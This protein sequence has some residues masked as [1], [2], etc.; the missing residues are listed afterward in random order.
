MEKTARIIALVASF[1]VTVQIGMI[2]VTGSAVCPT[3]ACKIVE[4]LTTIGP[5]GLNLIGVFYFLTLFGV[6]HWAGG[7][8]DKRLS[9]VGLLLLAG[10]AA[11]MVLF[12]FQLIVVKAFCLY[13]LFIF[14]AI[15]FLN[16]LY[17]KK[18]I[19]AGMAVAG[20]ILIGFSL[21]NFKTVQS[22]TNFTLDEGVF[23]SR[24]CAA[25]TKE[26]YLIFSDECPHCLEV[27][28]A[29]EECNSCNLHLNPIEE[30]GDLEFEGI[31][32]RD[33]YSPY[34]NRQILSIMGID[35]I[36]VL[37][38]EHTDGFQFIQGE[39]RIIDYVRHACFQSEP[40][41]Y[42]NR[43]RYPDKEQIS[44]YSED[45]GECS[46]TVDCAEPGT[47]TLER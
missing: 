29:L 20:A 14:A 13:C 15:L 18:Q 8:K 39:R 22:S 7:R 36:P 25:P 10:L 30:V 33:H 43:S 21:V 41:L 2:L 24:T 32:K 6:L 26:L 44:A 9:W 17:G 5:L 40:T 16:I 47:S 37:L 4:E 42:L 1:V 38:V 19:L 34:I 35:K 45:E 3:E 23:G 11:E 46:V 12:S 31:V 27:I 28:K